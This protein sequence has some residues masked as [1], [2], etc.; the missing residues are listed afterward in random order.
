MVFSYNTLGQY[1]YSII[2]PS[3]SIFTGR[4]SILTERKRN[5]SGQEFWGKAYIDWKEGF[6]M[7][8]LTYLFLSGLMTGLSICWTYGKLGGDQV[9]IKN[10]P[11]LKK[12]LHYIHHWELGLI[13]IPLSYFV[14][15]PY[16]LAFLGWASGIALDDMLYHS[17]DNTFE[18]KFEKRDDF[19]E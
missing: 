15:I 11:H 18:K 9:W 7:F 12:F 17:F 13:C 5:F 4:E 8:E 6:G 19:D 1:F 3:V 14:P 10:H 16:S 2:H